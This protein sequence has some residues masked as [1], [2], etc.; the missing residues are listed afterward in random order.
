MVPIPKM[1]MPCFSRG[2]LSS[3]MDWESGTRAPPP[4]PW[5]ILKNH[6]ALE[7]PGRSAQERTHP[8]QGYGP[9][10]KVFLPIRRENHAAIAIIMAFDTR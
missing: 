2:K 8:E 1:A 7:A 6:K 10:K 4:I 9:H 5:T 3:R